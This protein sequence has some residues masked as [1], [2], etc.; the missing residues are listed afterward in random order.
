MRSGH[1]CAYASQ[2]ALTKVAFSCTAQLS[3][4][5]IVMHPATLKAG[6]MQPVIPTVRYWTK[7]SVDPYIDEL[8]VAAADS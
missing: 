5:E 7:F 8:E 2:H 4:P 1:L 6:V 3:E